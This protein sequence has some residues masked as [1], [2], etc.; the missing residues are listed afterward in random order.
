MTDCDFV[1]EV[2]EEY[3]VYARGGSEKLSTDRCTRTRRLVDAA[4]DIKEL[5][6]PEHS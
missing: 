3:L 6:E 2:G 4:A 1:F 5:G